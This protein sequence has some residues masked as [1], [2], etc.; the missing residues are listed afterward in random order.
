M[1]ASCR[2]RWLLLLGFAFPLQTL[3]EPN[4]TISLRLE[5]KVASLGDSAAGYTPKAFYVGSVEVGDREHLQSMQVAFETASGS[6][7]LDST[8]CT[9][10]A[11]LKHRRYAPNHAVELN[12]AG[13][14]VRTGETAILSVDYNEEGSASGSITGDMIRDSICLGTGAG[15]L[16]AEFG[17]LAAEKMTDAPFTQLPMDGLVGLS[18]HGLSISEPFNFL[19]TL[20]LNGLAR[21]FGL[22]LPS[23]AKPGPAELT[24]GGHNPDRTASNISWVPV[25]QP[26]KGFWQVRIESVWVGSEKLD[27]CS[28]GCRAIIDSSSSHLTV[29]SEVMPTLMEKLAVQ[30]PKSWFSEKE[31]CNEATGAP[32]TFVL[33]N[34]QKLTLDAKDYAGPEGKDCVAQLHPWDVEERKSTGTRREGD[35]VV[36]AGVSLESLVLGEPLLRKY[37][38]VFDAD[39][40]R[41]GFALARAESAEPDTIVLMQGLTKQTRPRR[42]RP[43]L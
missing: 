6:V 41:L 28:A 20:G 21:R 30:A 25:E 24:L 26:E 14:V 18:L 1:E 39:H 33:S 15:R 34:G 31:L 36:A 35:R 9:S 5:R 17:L 40:S 10:P 8:R 3:A 2:G 4:R 32:L 23:A 7:V 42:K 16:C 11:C 37:Y 43:E 13:G 22:F 29:P 19:R 27:F 12:R 38:T